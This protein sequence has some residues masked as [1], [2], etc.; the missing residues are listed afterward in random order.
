MT[1]VMVTVV[2]LVTVVAV[3]PAIATLEPV[4]ATVGIAAG[5]FG[6]AVCVAGEV[7]VQ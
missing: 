1:V 6:I 5:L 4:D 2:L 7:Q 3:R